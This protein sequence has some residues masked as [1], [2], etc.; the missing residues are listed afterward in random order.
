M[1]KPTK[2]EMHAAIRRAR[3]TIR[4]KPGEKPFAEW[5]AGYKAEERALEDRKLSRHAPNLADS[6]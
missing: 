1:S 6:P 2:A 3:G 5:W 4:R